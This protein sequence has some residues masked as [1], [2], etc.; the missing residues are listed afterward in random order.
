MRVALTKIGLGLSVLLFSSICL[1]ENASVPT[2][3]AMKQASKQDVNVIKEKVSDFLQSYAMGYPGK[4]SVNVGAIDPYLKL[5]SCDDVQAFLPSGGR[6]WGKTTVGVRCASPSVWTIYVQAT[7]NVYGQYLVAAAPLVKGQ[8][9]RA[10]DISVATGDLTQL[11][12]GVLTDQAQVVGRT[13][14][15]SMQAG[16]VLRQD[17]LKVATVVQQGQT[18]KLISTGEGFSVSAEGQAVTKANEGDL[19]RVKVAS[20]QIITGIARGDGQVDVAN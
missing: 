11:A 19:V 16:T 17:L 12:S 10:H 15:V 1:A 2:K 13:V 20:G 3:L 4:V 5:A 8:L 18:V 7:L 9:I 6:A 14:N